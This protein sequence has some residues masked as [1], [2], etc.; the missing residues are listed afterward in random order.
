[1]EERRKLRDEKVEAE[2]DHSRSSNLSKEKDRQKE[3]EKKRQEKRKE[4]DKG[5][6]KSN[7][8]VEELERRAGKE[9]ERK[10]DFDKK[11][12]MDRRE[13]QKSG[14]ESGK[15]QNTNNAQNKN[16]T[17]NNYN[18]GGT[19]TRYLDRM[20]GTILSSSKAFGFGRGINVPSTVVKENKFNSLQ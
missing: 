13:H 6:S 16:V 18:R 3:A 10:R 11:S 8:D 17:A 5:S 19:G 1:M 12:E 9:S 20:R 14:L 2:K 15:G 7:S 4:K